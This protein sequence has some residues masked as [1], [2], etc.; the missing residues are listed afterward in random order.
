MDY[1]EATDEDFEALSDR[2]RNRAVDEL[3]KVVPNLQLFEL[4]ME[5]CGAIDELKFR[6]H[7]YEF[8]SGV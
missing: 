3:E 1:A 5:A 2:I 4:L 7:C 6:L 8:G